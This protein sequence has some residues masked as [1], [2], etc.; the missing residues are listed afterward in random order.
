[1]TAAPA[2]GIRALLL[3]RE[4]ANAAVLLQTYRAIADR[5]ERELA[6]LLA[7][8]TLSFNQLRQ[9][10]R[11]RTLL[12]QV[13][14]GIDLLAAVVE[15]R[16]TAEQ[17][18]MIDLAVQ[19]AQAQIEAALP[20]DTTFNRLPVEAINQIV[21]QTTGDTPLSRLLAGFGDAAA[22]RV[23]DKLSGGLGVGLAPRVIAQ[24]V[25]KA[26]NISAVRALAISRTEILG[27]YR[28]ASQE[29]YRA[30]DD[31]VSA[32]EWSAAHDARVCQFCKDH[33][34]KRYDLDVAFHS[35]VNCRCAVRPVVRAA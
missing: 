21:G 5:I 8:T 7:G 11:Y 18:A 19:Q 26:L 4:Q 6:M 30:N 12:D 29:I 20:V 27:A 10:D 34:G 35:H 14:R 16:V 28:R 2:T 31:V 22:Q 15:R 24:D 33:D 32:W 9:M 23:T 17:A 1:M 3:Q 13:R 25:R